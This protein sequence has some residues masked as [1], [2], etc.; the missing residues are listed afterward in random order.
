MH[1]AVMKQFQHDREGRG[2]RQVLGV[3]PRRRRRPRHVPRTTWRCRSASRAPF[4]TDPKNYPTKV[5][6]E[7]T[8]KAIDAKHKI[9]GMKAPA[10][11]DAPL[12]NVRQEPRRHGGRV[13]HLGEGRAVASRRARGR[14]QGRHLRRGVALV[15]RRQAGHRRRRLRSLPALRGP[16]RRQDEGRA[17][18][19][20]VPLQAVQGSE[21]PRA[22]CRTSAARKS[23]PTTRWRRRR[24]ASRPRSASW[25]PTI[26]S[27]RR[28][29]TACARAASPSAATTPTTSAAPGSTYM[30]AGRKVREVGKEA[31]A[32]K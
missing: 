28:S 21:V 8:P 31:L 4:G 7:C 1:V 6:E 30:E 23:P 3:P 20:G 25:R 11:Y 27:C 12:K 14:R 16:R 32:D 17:G 19:G 22:R 9:E 15:R 24:P 26:A 29:T 18:A 2:R 5:R 13:R 10:E